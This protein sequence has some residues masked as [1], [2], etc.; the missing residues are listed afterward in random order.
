MD[1]YLDTADVAEIRELARWG[2]L[3]G[4]TTNPSLVAQS[5][6][7]QAE[8]IAEITNIVPGPISAEVLSTEM[9]GMV[10]EGLE[11]AKIADNV[12]VKVPLTA[13]GLGAC[14]QLANRDIKV[15][16]TLCFS[17]NQAILA[18]QAG[19]WCVSPFIG[20]LDD[21]NQEG[22]DLIREICAIYEVQN[23]ETKVLAASIRHPQHVTQAALAGAD[24]ATMPAKV[25]R[26]MVKHPLT[27]AGL[28]KFL[29]DHAASMKH[30]EVRA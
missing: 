26:M 2:V 17:S 22:M 27:D 15:N 14:R 6:R 8:V 4:V 24:I 25:L 9:T 11:L 19:A 18:A 13:D 5:G 16:V 7:S 29:A 21:I 20:R 12:V 23:Y 3:A 10:K 1:L 30:G 28:A